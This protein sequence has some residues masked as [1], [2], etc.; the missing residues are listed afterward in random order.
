MSRWQRVL[1]TAAFVSRVAGFCFRHG[2][3]EYTRALKVL[4][5][6]EVLM[7]VNYG[8]NIALLAR[9]HERVFVKTALVCLAVNLAG[10]IL[11]I[12]QFSWRAAIAVF[13]I[14]TEFVL[15][16]QN[17]YWFK[18]LVGLFTNHGALRA[19]IVCLVVTCAVLFA[20]QLWPRQ[21]RRGNWADS[22]FLFLVKSGLLRDFAYNVGHKPIVTG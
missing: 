10:N 1:A 22:V 12:P 15:L 14:V 5:W 9:G 4:I 16:R 3:L 8:L 7:C 18:R 2:Y 19:T 11:F 13:T 6:A 20:K 21:Q 17:L